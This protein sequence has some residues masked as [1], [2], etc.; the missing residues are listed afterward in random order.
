MS[1]NAA[2]ELVRQLLEDND[3]HVKAYQRIQH[4][5]RAKD[6]YDKL[7]GL[8]QQAKR[9]F[10]EL[11]DSISYHRALGRVGLR[12]E[13]VLHQVYGANAEGYDKTF[14]VR[15]CRNVH[16]NNRT[17][18]P[19]DQDTCADCGEP[20]RTVQRSIPR[21]KLRLLYSRHLLGVDTKDGRRVW[22]DEP[23]APTASF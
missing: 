19:L 14:P 10:I 12:R 15:Q 9:K 22:F 21:D 4:W 18:R 13:D 3:E 8:K 17:R 20:L 11:G 1:V 7:H 2:K 5:D 16:C 23:I 6:A